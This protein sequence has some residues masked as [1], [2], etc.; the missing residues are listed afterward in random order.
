MGG[1]IRVNQQP[2]SDPAPTPAATAATAPAAAAAGSAT[3]S[4][5]AARRSSMTSKGNPEFPADHHAR[6]GDLPDSCTTEC[7]AVSDDQSPDDRRCRLS[8]AN[9]HPYRPASNSTCTTCPDLSDNSFSRGPAG[10][11]R[12]ATVLTSHYHLI[13]Q[14]VRPDA[15]SPLSSPIE[16]SL[17]P[18]CTST[19]LNIAYPIA[20]C[21]KEIEIV[22][23]SLS[24]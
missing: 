1:T 16:A 15:A 24:N 3:P 8:A 9:R 22:F 14:C 4:D 23:F 11:L 7:S 13:L 2:P 12:P 20:N 6:W 17:Q 21:K 19:E 5:A 18:F 10:V